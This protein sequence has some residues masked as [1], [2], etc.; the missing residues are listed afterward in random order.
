L[1]PSGARWREAKLRESIA[2]LN[3]ATAQVVSLVGE[4]DEDQS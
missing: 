2:R 3:A 4:I 1:R